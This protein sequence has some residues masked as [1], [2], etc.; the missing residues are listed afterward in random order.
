MLQTRHKMLPGSLVSTYQQY[1]EDT[2]AV[3]SWLASTAKLCGCPADLLSTDSAPDGGGSKR[4]GGQARKEAKQATA[5]Q[6]Q[7][8]VGKS[9]P[10]YTIAIKNFVP[11]AEIVAA[12]KEPLVSVPPSITA[13]LERV[14][15]TRLSFGDRLAEHGAAPS[16]RSDVQH[17]HFVHV[18][19]RVQEILKPC[20]SPPTEAA[21]P[22]APSFGSVSALSLNFTGLMSALSLNFTGLTV[23]LSEPSE[24]FLHAPLNIER[25][26]PVKDDSA[27]YEVE[28][29]M[30]LE[31][32]LFAY[33]TM[34]NDL[35]KIRA[36]VEWIWKNFRDG[37][38]DLAAA[39]VTTNTAC[40]L[41]R[42]LMEDMGPIFK[43]HGGALKTAKKFHLYQCLVKGFSLVSKHEPG[44]TDVNVVP[45]V[46][47]VSANGPRAQESISNPPSDNFNYDTY[48]VATDTCMIS[49]LML[50]SFLTVL[51]PD[52]LPL[53]K[54]GMFGVYDPSRDWN[55][56]SNRDKFIQD[57]ILMMEYFTEL[58]TVVRC[59]PNYPVQDEFLRGMKELD[60]T[61]EIPMYLAFAAQLFLDIHHILR[62]KVSTAQKTCM[63]HVALMN[64]DLALH[65]EFHKN[66]WINTWPASN[67]HE[68]KE[69]QRKIKVCVCPS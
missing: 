37:M 69:M 2:N 50:A 21:S 47:F 43:A 68:L 23:Y 45:Y 48:D 5:Q 62:E 17:S 10:K 7:K 36:H 24:D 52:H 11:L 46:G 15:S 63:S 16:L 58:M 12:S 29:L 22:S 19:Q 42:D 14:I 18:L 60:Q 4:L 28:P 44:P 1:K 13:T 34:L 27:T 38:F 35:A 57:K 65:L 3:A 66:L 26:A 55:T 56:M 67:D 51:D 33:T 31:E 49:F 64:E 32:A 8:P 41:A 25:L 61:R 39:A 9:G 53:Y 40:D 30:D 54:E 6:H 20:T 59:V